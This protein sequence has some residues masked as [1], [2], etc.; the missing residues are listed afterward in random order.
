MSRPRIGVFSGY[1]PRPWVIAD[2]LESDLRAVRGLIRRLEALG[3]YEIVW[4]GRRRRGADKVVHSSELARRT[5]RELFAA[6]V[7]AIVNLHPTWT[8]PQLSQQVV[9]SYG[10]LLRE[11]DPSARPRLVLVSIQDTTV[12]GMVSGM[13]TGGA[14]AQIGQSFDH[15][16]GDWQDPGLLEELVAALDLAAARAAS[17][18]RA[19]Q[20]VAGLHRLHALEFGSFSLQMPTTRIDQEELTRRYGITSESLDQQVFLDRA[21]AMFDW[22]GEPGRSP[23]RRIRHAG[24]REAVAKNYDADPSRFGVLPGR[25]VS[26]DKYALQ[27]AMYFAVAEIAEEKGAGAVTIK[28]QDEC[29]GVYATCCQATS[30]LGNDT[31]PNGRR[32]RI[33]PTSCETDLPTMYTQYLLK[34]L[35]GRPSGFGDF[36]FVRT[37]TDPDL[38]GEPRTLLA[39]VNCGQHPL[40]FAGRERDSLARKRAAVDYPGQEHFYAAGGAAVRMRTAGGQDMTVARLGVENGRLHLVACPLRTVDVPVE[41]HQAYNPSWPI[42]EGEVPVSD[43]VLGRRWPSN[44]LGFVYGDWTAALIELAERMDLGYTIWDRAGREHHRPS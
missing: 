7:D 16:F 6:E 26:R 24:V 36:R 14:F 28:C 44:H 31:D 35:S 11:A 23:I 37:W 43:Q 8:F 9:T 17:G 15:V 27:V 32:K 30:F 38:G 13:A 4:P 18:P 12:P 10:Q 5:A 1:D 40:W 34:E 41:R 3:R 19:R 42:I 39:I 25:E 29:S 33:V 22:A 21:F 2:C 20:V